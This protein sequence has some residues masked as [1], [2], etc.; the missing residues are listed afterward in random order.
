MKSYINQDCLN[1]EKDFLQKGQVV[2]LDKE[3]DS[4]LFDL[5]LAEEYDEAKHGL[6]K[7]SLETEKEELAA[8]VLSLQTEKEELAAKVLSLQTEKAELIAMLK[9]AIESPKGT[10]PDGYEKYGEEA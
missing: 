8:K 10:K 5:G 4:K 3:Q 6:V 2:E 9:V 7:P 1:F